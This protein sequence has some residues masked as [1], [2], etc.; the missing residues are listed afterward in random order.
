MADKKNADQYEFFL[1]L[2]ILIYLMQK[3]SF[4]WNLE[5]SLEKFFPK[6]TTSFFLPPSYVRS[7]LRIESKHVKY[8]FSNYCRKRVNT[9]KGQSKFYIVEPVS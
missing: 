9:T 8:R 4:P 2:R 7:S 6:L 3:E 1:K 5:N